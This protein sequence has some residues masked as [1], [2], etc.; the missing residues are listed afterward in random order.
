M[1]LAV[2]LGVGW[3]APFP[4]FYSHRAHPDCRAGRCHAVDAGPRPG[5]Q[6][7][8]PGGGRRHRR[9]VLRPAGACLARGT[10]A[11]GGPAVAPRR[12]PHCAGGTA[13]ARRR[14]HRGAAARSAD[15]A[16]RRPFGAPRERRRARRVRSGHRRGVA[17]SRAARRDR[18]RVRLGRC[19]ERRAGAAGARAARSAGGGGT[20]GS[21]AG[22]WRTG[23][24]G[25]V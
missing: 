16:G 1:A 22:G 15:R 3:A 21:A 20:D 23:R 24:G 14:C 13:P 18:P 6:R 7:R 25:A 2:M 17:A 4:G 9:G 8:A 12:R 19:A 11:R 10:G 5:D